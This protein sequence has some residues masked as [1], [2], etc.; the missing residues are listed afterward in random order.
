MAQP[1]MMELPEGYIYDPVRGGIEYIGTDE[2][3]AQVKA[4]KGNTGI[5]YTEKSGGLV[6]HCMDKDDLKY[7]Y[8]AIGKAQ[9]EPTPNPNIRWV[10]IYVAP[11]GSDRYTLIPTGKTIPMLKEDIIGVL[12]VGPDLLVSVTTHFAGEAPRDTN[13]EYYWLHG[14][15]HE[16]HYALEQH[17]HEA[18][19]HT[20]PEYVP[21]IEPTKGACDAENRPWFRSGNRVSRGQM[22]KIQVLG[23]EAQGFKFEPVPEGQQTFSDVPPNHP[24]YIYIEKLA[25]IGAINGYPCE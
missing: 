20:H 21:R 4:V 24:F 23:M 2:E 3:K 9:W 5:A 15:C 10:D 8:L 14:I 19:P 6:G 13:V 7:K 16:V 18:I 22:C 11:P 1:I 12:V 17:T 25:S